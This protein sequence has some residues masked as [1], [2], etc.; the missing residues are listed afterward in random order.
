MVCLL[1]DGILLVK[2]NN[3][4]NNNNNKIS[5]NSKLVYSTA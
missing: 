2:N 1:K 5:I 3:N 4:N